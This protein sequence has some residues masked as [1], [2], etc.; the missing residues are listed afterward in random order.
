MYR[1]GCLLGLLLTST[2]DSRRHSTGRGHRTS[3]REAALGIGKAGD[4]DDVKLSN[5]V[6]PPRMANNRLALVGTE[7]QKSPDQVLPKPNY[8][9]NERPR[10][11]SNTIRENA[12]GLSGR[13]SSSDPLRNSGNMFADIMSAFASED[14]TPVDKPLLG[15]VYLDGAAN[16]LYAS[17]SFCKMMCIQFQHLIFGNYTPCKDKMHRILVAVTLLL[18]LCSDITLGSVIVSNIWCLGD[19]IEEECSYWG[20]YVFLGIYPCAIIIAPVGGLLFL[21]FS[22]HRIC[23]GTIKWNMISLINALLGLFLISPSAPTPYVSYIL[24]SAYV[25]VKIAI[26]FFMHLHLATLECAREGVGWSGLKTVYRPQTTPRIG[27]RRG[28]YKGKERGRAL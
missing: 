27:M 22:W 2:K 20:L 12:L 14:V 13:L 10:R 16:Q 6:E 23:R 8:S 21:S 11:N 25:C 4:K 7:K 28:L 1:S 19:N 3:I 15:A 26:N 18:L 17:S 9:Q 24:C 5:Q